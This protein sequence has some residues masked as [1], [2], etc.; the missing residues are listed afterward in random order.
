MT[1]IARA[2]RV[3][4]P[5][6]TVLA[7]IAL[8]SLGIGTYAAIAAR[9]F[10]PLIAGATIVPSLWLA[11]RAIGVADLRRQ[12][13]S[14][15]WFLTYLLMIFWPA[16]FVYVDFPGA[17][18]NAFLFAVASALLT[19]PAGALLVARRFRSSRAERDAYL[20]KP[21]AETHPS[22]ALFVLCLAIVVVITASVVLYFAML[23]EVPLL[24]MLQYPGCDF[25]LAQLREETFKLLDPRWNA[26]SGTI[27]F[28]LF[29][30]L[31]TIIDPFIVA[32]LFGIWF[33]SRERRWLMLFIVVLLVASLYAASSL[34]R[35]PAAALVLRM[36]FVYYLLR[37]G[38]VSFRAAA[39]WGVAILA[40]PLMVTAAAYRPGPPPSD[41]GPAAGR[42]PE[43][44][45]AALIDPYLALTT[46]A[47]ASPAPSLTATPSP[48]ESAVAS[49]SASAP[50]A[51]ATPHQ[52]LIVTPI[53]IPTGAIPVPTVPPSG[54]TGEPAPT[55][56][57]VS[58]V[59]PSTPAPVARAEQRAGDLVG[60]AVLVLRR[61]SY[62]EAYALFT[63]F[64]VF[65][66]QHDWLF[67]QTLMKPILR[68]W[69]TDFYVE[70]YVYV[71][72]FPSS[73][74]P[75]GH[76]NAAFQSNFYADFGLPGV[77]VGGV[78][79]GAI[80]HGLEIYLWRRRKTIL[81]LATFA[82]LVYAFWVLH[83]GSLTSVLITNGALP[84]LLIAPTM[85]LGEWLLRRW[86]VGR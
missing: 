85:R 9:E 28:Y 54:P 71:K 70:N 62:T 12:T 31:R 25:V 43:I 75:T 21:L 77:L 72:T 40:F 61:L 18:R 53:P 11:E 78:I 47:R 34:A 66:A 80:M 76:L 65:P 50:S 36:F 24:Y 14:S 86:G 30:P 22:V 20:E 37:A 58:L 52:T 55:L 13:I 68:F 1:G 26:A 45:K 32:A 17:E 73:P 33:V 64:K 44:G 38:G 46:I 19:A 23:T 82:V 69:G 63:Y 27:L 49:A 7:L 15:V 3:W 79:T 4:D 5:R 41:C 51:S 83:S 39:I 48:S 10:L 8:L 2:L 67:G 84:V 35:A 56:P 57:V 60:S 29:L 81:E 59:R 16:F 6:P 42:A 74:I